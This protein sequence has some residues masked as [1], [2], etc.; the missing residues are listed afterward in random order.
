MLRFIQMLFMATVAGLSEFPAEAVVAERWRI[1]QIKCSLGDF[2]HAW[3][4][5]N[6]RSL[7]GHP[8][9]DSR[10]IDGMLQHFGDGSEYLCLLEKGGETTGLCILRRARPGIWRSFLPT[11]AQLAPA[12]LGG[13]DD[14]PSLLAALPGLVGQLDLLCQDPEFSP[15]FRCDRIPIQ[16]QHHA[17]TMNIRTDGSFDAYWSERSKNL[18]GTM[19]SRQNRVAKA[20]FQP[21]V[22][23]LTGVAQMRDAVRRFAALETSGWKGRAGTALGSDAV[24]EPFYA[25]IMERFAE[26]GQAFI[27]EY[28]LDE[29]LAASQLAIAAAPMLVLLKTTYD[30]EFA[31]CSPGRLLLREV[32]RDGFERFPGGSIEFYT[33]ADADQL[34][35]AT[36]YRWIEHVTLYRNP[37]VERVMAGVQS[38]RRRSF[39]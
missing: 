3:D 28:W 9:L 19:R 38:L 12:I 16:T 11:Q 25:D 21:R 22:V 20:G 34:A 27:Y 5:L 32:I 24:Q 2:A 6:Q 39:P 35:W 37:A 23:C 15:A 17:L 18:R 33:N 7:A 30:E 36:G 1:H 4:R 31:H 29:R 10:F 13:G 8:M 26:T 14:L